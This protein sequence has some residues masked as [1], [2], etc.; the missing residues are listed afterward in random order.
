MVQCGLCGK[1]E[2]WMD[3]WMGEPKEWAMG[4]ELCTFEATT[5]NKTK[6]KKGQQPGTIAG[7]QAV[8]PSLPVGASASQCQSLSP[9]PRGKPTP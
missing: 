1:K 2:G 9:A 5:G 6:K 8:M 4:D 3:G 7:K